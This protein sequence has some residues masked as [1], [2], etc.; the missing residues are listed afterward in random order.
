MFIWIFQIDIP[1]EINIFAMM[2]IT[3]DVDNL[4]VVDIPAPVNIL[5]EWT[6]RLGRYSFRLRGYIC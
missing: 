3:A 2:D 5:A 6:L 1:N 4:A